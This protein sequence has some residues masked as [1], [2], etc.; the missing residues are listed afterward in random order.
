MDW[1]AWIIDVSRITV[2]VVSHKI[3]RIADKCAA[4]RIQA[5]EDGFDNYG[6]VGKLSVYYQGDRKQCLFVLVTINKLIITKKGKTA[7][8]ER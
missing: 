5:H 4:Q 6:F 7:R 1:H 3:R 8:I 2:R